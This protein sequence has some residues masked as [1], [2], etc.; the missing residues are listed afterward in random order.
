MDWLVCDFGNV[1][2]RSPTDADVAALAEL[3][4]RDRVGFADAYWA[5]RTDYDRGDLDAQRYWVGVVVGE[6]APARLAAC[7]AA[8][9]ASWTRLEERSMSGVEECARRG[10]R[11]ALLS[12]APAEIARALDAMPWFSRFEHRLFSCDVRLAKP[13]P[14]IFAVL[15]DRLEAAPAEV[16]FVDD[17]KDNVDAA[18]ALG[19]RAVQFDAPDVFDRL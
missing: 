3:C 5:R 15:L 9:I 16:T 8:D 12:N 18:S 4:G 14:A 13:D 17:R 7:V 6:L 11:L 1:I 10:A 2:S 19:I